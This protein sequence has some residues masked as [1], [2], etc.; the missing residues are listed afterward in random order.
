M[1]TSYNNYVFPSPLLNCSA[2]L[3][4]SSA[5]TT[6]LLLHSIL[7]NFLKSLFLFPRRVSMT[8]STW[9]MLLGSSLTIFA[10]YSLINPPAALSSLSRRPVFIETLSFSFSFK[11]SNALLFQEL[12]RPVSPPETVESDNG[13][14][15]HSITG[16][17]VYHHIVL[18]THA[19]YPAS[20][21]T[22]HVK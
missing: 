13:Q 14:G 1:S 6:W 21:I 18:R 3:F 17:I 8:L 10:S 4:S 16:C 7:Q 5:Q 12:N 19:L 22:L 20:Q 15:T 11:N 2:T 9:A